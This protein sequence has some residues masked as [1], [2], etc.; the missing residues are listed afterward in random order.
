[1]DVPVER[2]GAI[3][4]N[5]RATVHPSA[6]AESTSYKGDCFGSFQ[7]LPDLRKRAF[8]N[9]LVGGVSKADADTE[10]VTIRVLQCAR[11]RQSD[12]GLCCLHHQR[13]EGT[14]GR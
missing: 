10:R 11:W 5:A 6:T 4:V 1:M 13:V 7:D 8:E 2:L 14:A 12:S 9:I 3:V